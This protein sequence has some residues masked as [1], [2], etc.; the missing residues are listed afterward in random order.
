MNILRIN[1]FADWLFNKTPNLQLI[2][3]TLSMG[4]GHYQ[5]IVSRANMSPWWVSEKSYGL[6]FFLRQ[7]NT[8][9]NQERG[10]ERILM[11]YNIWNNMVGRLKVEVD[12]YKKIRYRHAGRSFE[13]HQENFEVDQERILIAHTL[14]LFLYL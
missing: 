5:N 3:A 13:S 8:N 1:L 11:G 2:G 9:F 10:L 4:R 6:Q 7:K 14:F 12:E